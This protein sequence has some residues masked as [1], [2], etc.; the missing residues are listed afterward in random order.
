VRN[1]SG[2]GSYP[3]GEKVI[4]IADDPANNQE[5]KNWTVDPTD[6]KL[7]SKYVT[8]TVIEM[9]AKDVLV[10]ANYKAK[11]S[12]GMVGSGGSNN[13]SGSAGNVGNGQSGNATNTNG[14][15]VVINKNG[16]SNTGVVAVQVNGSS[17]NFVI[18][19]SENSA[20]TESA[21]KAL[22]GKFGS[23]DKIVYFPMDISLYDSTGTKQI[24]DTTGLSINITLPIPDSMV[25]YAGNNK[26]AAVVNDKLEELPATFKTISGVPC[27]SFTATHFSPYVIYADT[28][29]LNASVIIDSTPKTGDGV[30]PKWFLSMGL[31]CTSVVLFLK[32]DKKPGELKKKVKARACDV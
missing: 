10:T 23:L 26:V 4:I 8:A 18:K 13:N 14:T 7:A 19:I 31:M 22:M 30:H 9:P 5:F 12:S 16:L 17:D 2:S 3:A 29:N 20:A 1:G 11:P 25:T 28:A 27:I 15:T 21:L 32:K 24:T 6:V